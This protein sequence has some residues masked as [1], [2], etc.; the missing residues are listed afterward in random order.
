MFFYCIFFKKSNF[1]L[2][3]LTPDNMDAKKLTCLKAETFPLT[4]TSL[5]SKQSLALDFLANQLS[6]IVQHCTL[7]AQRMNTKPKG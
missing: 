2:P 3:I 6:H 1:F 5:V 7:V 4:L